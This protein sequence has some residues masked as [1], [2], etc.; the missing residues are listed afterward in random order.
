MS[1]TIVSQGQLRYFLPVTIKILN[2]T[3][4][5]QFFYKIECIGI[6]SRL[7]ARDKNVR[8]YPIEMLGYW[9]DILSR[10]I[11]WYHISIFHR[12]SRR[13]PKS[14]VTKYIYIYSA[15]CMHAWTNT[16]LYFWWDNKLNDTQPR[17][18]ASVLTLDSL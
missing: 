11:R 10:Y 2:A 17:T 6:P 4:L 1:S 18:Q 15:E 8:R 3:R 13:D 7:H 16:N 12:M 9:R 14:S 5:S